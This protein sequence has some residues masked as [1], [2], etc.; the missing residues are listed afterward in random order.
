[1]FALLN[2]NQLFDISVPFLVKAFIHFLL[3]FLM[4]GSFSLTIEKPNLKGATLNRK[5]SVFAVAILP[6]ELQ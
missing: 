3:I 5:L 4:I 2:E 1:M 6:L